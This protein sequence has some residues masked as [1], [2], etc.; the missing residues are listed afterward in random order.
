M[1]TQECIH[2][3]ADWLRE[4]VCAELRY[5]RAMADGYAD[6][7]DFERV[8]VEP[9][10]YEGAMPRDVAEYTPGGDEPRHIIAPC[11]VV[12]TGGGATLSPQFGEVEQ[13]IRLLVQV[14]EPGNV[15]TR[16]DGTLEISPGDE[17]Y[18]TITAFV[19]RLVTRLAEAVIPGGVR[20]VGDVAFEYADF[21]K[22]ENWPYYPAL[23]SFKAQYYRNLKP[24]FDL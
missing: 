8:E 24:Q 15:A 11:I 14:W 2:L 6:R 22:A 16:E 7:D 23:V 9:A 4:N 21:S 3:L 5:P 13:Q 17:G 10:V 19:D 12:T 20:V 18:R 1:T